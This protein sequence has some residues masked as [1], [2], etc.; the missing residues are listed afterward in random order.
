MHIAFL[1]NEFVIETPNA[2][3]LGTYLNRITRALHNQGH[4]VEIFVTRKNPQTPKIIDYQGI[5][6]EHVHVQKRLIIKIINL[7]DWI[8]L[9]S[10]WSI[11]DYFS[12]SW[13]LAKA[14]EKRH[15]EAPFDFVQSTN[16]SASGLFVRKSPDRPLIVR[17]S[18]I[19]ELAFESDGRMGNLGAK[20]IV[21]LERAAV[22][23]GDLIY[24]PSQFSANYY[25]K[26]NK[27][28]VHVLRPPIFIEQEIADAVPFDIPSRFLIHFGSI[29]PV[30]GSDWLAEALMIW[31]GK[32]RIPGEMGKYRALWGRYANNII[33]HGPIEKKILYALLKKSIASVLPSRVD[34]LPNTVIES[35]MLGVPVIGSNGASIDELVE[36]GKSGELV[37]IGDAPGL[38]KA[39]LDAWN[40]NVPWLE[41]GFVSPAILS[42]LSPDKAAENLLKLATNGL[43]TNKF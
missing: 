14:L 15:A 4:R 25:E 32:E 19:R 34:N 36:S 21:W 26:T 24:A 7:I 42:E 40:G 16:L 35:L 30:K 10:P 39:M 41:N 18:S 9:R 37:S 31:A 5:R 2:G 3:G 13:N 12:R 43:P 27:R 20:I 22:N 1:S 33:W 29:G 23:R 11:D 8:F 17:L 38:A 6:V 28:K